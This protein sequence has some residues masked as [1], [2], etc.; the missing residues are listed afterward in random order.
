[1]QYGF[2]EHAVKH[3]PIAL[4]L[5]EQTISL[6]LSGPRPWGFSLTSLMDDPAMGLWGW[7]RNGEL[8]WTV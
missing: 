6:H 3:E 1:M 5:L 7:D 4:Q 2:N 8:M